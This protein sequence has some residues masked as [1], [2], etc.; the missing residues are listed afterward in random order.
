MYAPLSCY[1]RVA[2]SG[3]RITGRQADGSD[4]TVRRAL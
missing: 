3:L 2:D 1:V 4:V